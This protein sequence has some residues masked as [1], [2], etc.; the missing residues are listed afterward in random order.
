[1]QTTQS[2][3]QKNSNFLP[4]AII[5]G[6]FFI[7]GFVTWLNG[8]LIPFLQTICDL[9]AFQAM[10]VASAFYAAYTIMALPMSYIIEKTGYKNGMSLGLF[11]VAAGALI[12]IPAAYGRDF[13]IFLLAQ[14]V[15]G[16]GLTILQTAS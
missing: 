9:T 5:G 12:F 3:P 4:M 8:A 2:L 6:L 11:I 15:V 10:L 13:T 1:M 7:F 16:S 14:F